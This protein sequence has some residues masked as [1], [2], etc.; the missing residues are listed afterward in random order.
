MLLY[1]GVCFSVFVVSCGCLSFV[2]VVRVGGVVIGLDHLAPDPSLP[3]PIPP[4]PSQDPLLAVDVTSKPHSDDRTYVLTGQKSRFPLPV[5]SR[6]FLRAPSS[7]CELQTILGS[8]RQFLG[9]PDSSCEFQSPLQFQQAFLRSRQLLGAQD[10]SCELQTAFETSSL[11]SSSEPLRVQPMRKSYRRCVDIFYFSI[12]M[13]SK[14]R[15]A[16][17]DASFTLLHID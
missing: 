13:N 3:D 12:C 1:V 17:I 10:N 6:H 15:S 2:V 7:S 16:F 5:S 11:P 14:L 9:A 8:S 4:D